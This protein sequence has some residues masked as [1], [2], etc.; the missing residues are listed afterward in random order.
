MSDTPFRQFRNVE[1]STVYYIETQVNAN[2]TNVSVVKAFPEDT[3]ATLPVIS[4]RVLENFAERREIGSRSMIDR[5]SVVID[6][7][8]KHAGQRLDLAQFIQD[9]IEEDYT[10]YVHSQTS[11]NPGVLSRSSAGKLVFESLDQNAKIDFGEDV[12][13]YDKNRHVIAYTVRLANA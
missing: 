1:L 12:D 13:P 5:Y 4:V 7:F 10:Y 6:I 9:T 2:W 11:G 8:A 3:K